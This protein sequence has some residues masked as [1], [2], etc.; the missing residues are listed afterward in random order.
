MR[1]LIIFFGSL[2][3][4]CAQAQDTAITRHNKKADLLLTKLKTGK[5]TPSTVL[6]LKMAKVFGTTVEA[7][8]EPEKQD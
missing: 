3:G 6:A 2:T 4:L 8:F 1:F 5:F 7:I